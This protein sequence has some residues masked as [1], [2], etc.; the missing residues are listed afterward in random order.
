MDDRRSTIRRHDSRSSFRS[1]NPNV[2]SDDYVLDEYE[3]VADGRPPASD[4]AGGASI[5]S[6]PTLQRSLSLR[7]ALESPRGSIRRTRL[8]QRSVGQESTTSRSDA[9]VLRQPSADLARSVSSQHRSVRTISSFGLPR[10][11][12]PYQGPTGPSQPYGMYSQDASLGRSPSVVTTSTIRPPE[13]AYS[14]P[15][16]PTQPYAMYPQNTMP[17][18]DQETAGLA[19]VM[20][21]FSQMAQPQSQ[22]VRRLGPE[23][24][25][26]DDLIGPD[27]Y[28]EQ[29]PPYSRYAN[30]IPPKVDP[31]AA[32]FISQPPALQ[33]QGE[34]NI[35]QP[36]ALGYQ[37]EPSGYYRP[38]PR[39]VL[40][41]SQGPVNP[42]DDSSAL[43]S[44]TTAINSLPTTEK[45]TFKQR[46]QR[47]GNKRVC[48]GLLPC[49]ALVF[50]VVV[51]CAAMLL[52]GV[53][54]GI[55][56]HHTSQRRYPTPHPQ[57]QPQE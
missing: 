30:G 11:Q 54:G 15:A 55:V 31:G 47:K 56:A 8:S 22:A 14:G 37:N 43:S 48:C 1:S 27:G 34:S 53:I 4:R 36:G 32:N 3:P 10:A 12:S 49:W 28:T 51:L 25:D 7:Q 5:S 19:P 17:E 45:G 16:G 42:F 44:S 20:P 2:F 46:V 24:E 35:A 52:G 57:P 18:D 13:R 26:A 29:L 39:E 23:G 40:P 21:G 38:E 33:S 9:E 50:M 6:G 41:A